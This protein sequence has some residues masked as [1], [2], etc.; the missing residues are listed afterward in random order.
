MKQLEMYQI[1]IIPTVAC[2]LKCRLCSNYSPYYL[3]RKHYSI[4]YLRE[5]LRR[6]FTVV[7]YVRKLMITGGEP[8]L[9]P[10]LGEFVMELRKYRGQIGTFGIITNGTLL[11]DETLLTAVTDF[12]CDFH[13]LIDN[14]GPDL[15]RR[16]EELDALLTRRN[17]EHTMHNYR[18]D[19]P[20]CGGFVDFGNLRVKRAVTKED[21]RRRFAKCAFPKAFHFCFDLVGG[22]MFPCNPCRR[23][24]ELGIVDDPSEYVDLFDDSLTPEEQREKIA[25]I[26]QRDSLAACAYCDG[27]C[28]DS[29]RFPAAQQL[30]EAE[31]AR[32]RAGASF[33]AD[34]EKSMEQYKEPG[35]RI[36][37]MHR[38]ELP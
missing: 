26:Y 35:A 22:I 37:K 34:V 25:A 32:I 10:A 13:F 1:G 24:K 21:M 5:T 18:G 28:E 31:L 7:S 27:M 15:S 20:H 17:I 3:D 4:D 23:C 33:Y 11:P 8:L 9:Y 12:G 6:Y 36:E 29:P 19:S 38:E 2:D 30:E 16:A 14:Y